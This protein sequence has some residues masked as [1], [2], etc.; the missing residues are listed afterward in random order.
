[1]AQGKSPWFRGSWIADY[2]D[3][4]NYMTL[5]YSPNHSPAGPNYTHF[6]SQRFDRLYRAAIRETDNAKRLRMYREMDSLVMD[7]APVIVLYYDQIL[8]FTHKNISGMSTNAMNALDLRFTKKEL[9]K[10]AGN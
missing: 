8:H 9:T 2:P 5:F 6:T 3:A 1:M 4:E 10:T 7:E